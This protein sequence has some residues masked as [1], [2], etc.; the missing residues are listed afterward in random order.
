MK[1][2][3][4][5]WLGTLVEITIFDEVFD[6][7]AFDMAFA[8]IARDHALMSFHAPD[9]DVSKINQAT[10]NTPIQVAAETYAVLQT[11]LLI[12]RASSGLFNIACAPR[13]V[14]W[15]F[16]PDIASS[17]SSDNPV[18]AHEALWLT[19][20]Q[21]VIKRQPC[22]IDLGGIAKGFA[23]DQALFALQQA[24]VHHACINAGG[25]LR[26]M[27]ESAI[28]VWI[29]HPRFAD[30]PPIPQ[31]LQNRAMATSGTYFSA[32]TLRDDKVSALVN[33]INLQAVIK[34]SSASVVAESCMVADALTKVVIA[35]ENAYHSLLQQFSAHAIYLD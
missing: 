34:L 33:G 30:T 11:A 26:C 28:P 13:M 5:P 18:Q 7:I 8:S 35:T 9:S 20:D 1:R 14:A 19:S 2:R 32:K 22:L 4:Q 21:S 6:N 15:E 25:D 12:G 23:V 31:I 10:L 17:S 29:R 27:G 24:G 3:A 16:L